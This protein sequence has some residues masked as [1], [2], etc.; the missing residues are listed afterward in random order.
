MSSR[1]FLDTFVSHNRV[2]TDT[3]RDNLES[4]LGKL[5]GVMS[6]LPAE[7]GQYDLTE[8]TLAV[9][10]TAKGSVSLLGSGGEVSGQGG[11]TLKLTRKKPEPTG[12]QVAD[13]AAP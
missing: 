12:Q 8:M 6:S 13:K 1:G 2:K 5:N 3:L 10:V 4:L 11:I 9:S 7:I